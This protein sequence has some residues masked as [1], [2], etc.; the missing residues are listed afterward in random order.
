MSFFIRFRISVI[1]AWRASAPSR[2]GKSITINPTI[3]R[4][5]ISCAAPRAASRE[6]ARRACRFAPERRPQSTSIVVRAE[7]GSIINRPPPSSGTT[8]CR[9]LAIAPTV[10]WRSKSAPLLNS[11]RL[12]NPGDHLWE[13]S[14]SRVSVSSSSVKIR[15]FEGSL[16]RMRRSTRLGPLA[17]SKGA[18][19]SSAVARILCQYRYKRCTSARIASS[20][21]SSAALRIVTPPP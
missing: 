11:K 15:A 2:L 9:A 7:V 8:G 6:A 19:F 10:S 14:E 18:L 12:S 5:R 21:V 1:S 20:S 4:R 13:N 17:N 16:S 3:F